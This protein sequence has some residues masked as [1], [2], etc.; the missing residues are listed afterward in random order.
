VKI[1]RSIKSMSSLSR[2]NR[3]KGKT[4]GLVPTMGALHLG[5]LSLI[6]KARRENDLTVV[7]IF[8]NP[9]QFGPKED[10]KKYPRA[11]KRDARLCR[12]EKVDV[13]FHPEAGAIYPKDYKTYIEVSDLSDCLCG[14]SRPGHFRGVTTIVAKLFNIIQPDNAYFGQ[15]DAQQAMIIKKMTNDL[16][17]SVKVRVMPTVREKD[18]LAMSSR[19][20]YLNNQERK[21][22]LLIPQALSLAKKLIASGLKDTNKIIDKMKKFIGKS[23]GVKIDYIAIVNLDNLRPFKKLGDSYLVALAVRIGKTRLIDNIIV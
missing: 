7:S 5:H 6:R 8:V 21:T 4:I 3:I 1:I 9:A 16:H 17:M 11:L 20:I 10:F 12:L 13:I 2:Q 15:K 23:R 14:A 22:A 19:N 18:G